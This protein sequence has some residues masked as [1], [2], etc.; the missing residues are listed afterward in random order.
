[1][2][3]LKFKAFEYAAQA[4][5]GR[6]NLDGFCVADGF[7]TP[8]GYAFVVAGEGRGK[9]SLAADALARIRYYLE[10]EVD[11]D[12][13]MAPR[14]ALVYTSGYLHQLIKKNPELGGSGL[15]CLCVL[16]RAGKLHYAW[17]GDVALILG[18]GKKV[19]PLIR[20]SSGSASDDY[21]GK[22]PLISP[23]Y[24]KEPLLPLA[25]D[26]L[27][28][29]VGES[30]WS[31]DARQLKRVF[32]DSMPLDAKVARL[33]KVS[34]TDRHEGPSAVLLVGF[35]GL[36][37]KRREGVVRTRPSKSAKPAAVKTKASTSGKPGPALS[38]DVAG[39]GLSLP[40][41]GKVS[42]R[43]A[44]IAVVALVVGYMIYDLLL[45]DPMPPRRIPSEIIYGD[46]ASDTVAVTPDDVPVIPDDAI[47][48]VQ[49]GDVWS[50]I[51]T[52]YRVCS[53]FIINHPSN[54]GR[55][56]RDGGLM[57]GERL[58]IPLLYSGDPNLNPDYYQYF[59]T[60]QVGGSCQN[61]NQ[62]FLDRFERDVLNKQ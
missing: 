46:A 41:F 27:M 59:S 17:V 30:A 43:H 54:L 45:Y 29:S 19:E 50:R 48:N 42:V 23:Q 36:E 51:Y 21:M 58:V 28:L 40:L 20:V 16:F 11:E 52:Q 1:M 22:Q 9:Q 35:K 7:E 61:V 26:Q 62:E 55:L 38:K 12:L 39:K 34:V 32:S 24:S 3:T 5:A 6:S 33:V 37:N 53:W 31:F 44:L 13:A 15:S 60:N 8:N 10:N 56:G 49:P 57:A 25:E 47:Y 18:A 2:T 4:D 14:N